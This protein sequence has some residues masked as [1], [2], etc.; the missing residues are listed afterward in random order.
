[1]T[2]VRGL[3]RGQ[4]VAEARALVAA[5]GLGALTIG[6]LEKRLPFTR[7]VIT[8]HFA[9]KEDIVDAVLDSAVAEIDAATL[10]DLSGSGTVEEKV[11]AVLKT[12]VRGFLD[13]PEASRILVSFWSRIPADPRAAAHHAA[14]FSRYRRQSARLAAQAKDAGQLPADLD[15]DAF[16][17]ILVALVVGIVTQSLFEPGAVDVEVAIGTAARLLVGGA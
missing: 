6:A 4:I 7:G 8:H 14:L 12:K 13:N 16:G 1:M 10:H 3:R 17:A 5:E 9:D 11:L 15:E 2:V